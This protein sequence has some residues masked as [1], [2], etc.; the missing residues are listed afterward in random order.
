MLLCYLA[1]CPYTSSYVCL[2]WSVLVWIVQKLPQ[3]VLLSSNLKVICQEEDLYH[4]SFATIL[5]SK[6]IVLT[7][8][9][10]RIIVYK[11]L[12]LVSLDDYRGARS[13]I[14]SIIYKEKDLCHFSF[15]IVRRLELSQPPCAPV[16]HSVNY[17]LGIHNLNNIICLLYIE[18]ILFE[19]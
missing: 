19:A 6:N 7:F 18:S 15:A 1:M 8:L 5:S 10:G 11:Y 13:A 9:V 2:F 12:K 3:G 17:T 14:T 4:F 16:S